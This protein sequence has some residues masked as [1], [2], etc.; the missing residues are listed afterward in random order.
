MPAVRVANVAFPAKRRLAGAAALALAGAAFPAGATSPCGDLDECRV[1][2]EIN[3][4]DGDIG[5]HFLGDADD[6]RELTIS[7]PDDGHVYQSNAKGDLQDQLF[8]ETFVES[9]EPPCFPDAGGYV[10]LEEFVARWA[11]GTYTFRGK[12]N[13]GEHMAG[14]TVL[15]H[16]LPAAPAG[17]AFDEDDGIISWEEGEDLGECADADEIEDLVEEEVLPGFPALVELWEVVLEAEDDDGNVYKFS[18]RMPGG[19][20]TTQVTVPEEFLD[21]LPLDAELKIEVGAIG[22]DENAT[23]TELEVGED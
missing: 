5:F 4:S 9:S 13:Y 19:L 14:E 2:I 17:V 6:L 18:V 7:G 1:T 15:T 21:S 3:A 12:S 23:F 16:L 20:L 8:T 10:T 11:A 22:G